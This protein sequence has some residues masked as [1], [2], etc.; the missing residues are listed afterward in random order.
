M[1]LEQAGSTDFDERLLRAKN[2]IQH[3]LA[4]DRQDPLAWLTE[5][6]DAI[7][8]IFAAHPEL[9]NMFEADRE[10]AGQFVRERLEE[11]KG[12]VVN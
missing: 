10:G 12:E 2:F 3:D 9:I 8:R 11:G 5:N 7:R 1:P 6:S 4:K